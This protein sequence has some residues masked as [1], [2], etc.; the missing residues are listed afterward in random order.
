MPI[1]AELYGG[2]LLTNPAG[3][4]NGENWD[5]I[6][7]DVLLAMES[8]M[9]VCMLNT[10]FAVPEHR[11]DEMNAEVRRRVTSAVDKGKLS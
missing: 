1:K 6:Q 10:D 2:E 7:E 5:V 4:I 3:V 8:G 9:L 11:R